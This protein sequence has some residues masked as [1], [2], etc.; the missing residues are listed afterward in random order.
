MG[1]EVFPWLKSL[2]L[3]PEY[4]PTVAEFQDPISYIFKI[5]KE[6]SKYGICKIIPPVS[7]SPKKTIISNLNESLS[8]QNP[9]S[10]PTFTTRRQQIGFCPRKHFR[11]VQK[12]VW[13]S[14]E[15][16]TLAQFEAKAKSFEK[17][18][19]K[20]G[21]NPKRG[22]N[23]L[24]VE[25]LYWKAYMDKPFSIEYAND[26][27]G[28]AFDQ[29]VGGL[30]QRKKEIGDVM[31]VAESQ[32]NMNAASRAKGSLLRFIKE[33]ISG[34]NSPMVYMSMLFSWFAW[35]VEDHDLHSLNYMHMG[36]SKTWY[37]VPMDAA[38][39]FEDVVRAHGYGGE[40]NPIETVATLAKKN[41]VMSPEVLLKAGV[42]CCR[43]VQNAGEFVVTFPRAYHSGFSHGFNCAEATNIATPGWLMVARDAAI[44]RVI[45]NFAPLVSHTQLHYD[46]AL[47]LSANGRK[48]IR[49]EPRSSRLKDKLKGEGEAMVKRLFL[50]DMMKN[51]KLLDLLGQ[52]SPI[53]VLSEEALDSWIP[54]NS[55]TDMSL[56]LCI[57]NDESLSSSRR[58]SSFDS[59]DSPRKKKMVIVK[60]GIHKPDPASVF[61]CVTCGILC[62]SCVAIVQPSKEAAGYLMSTRG[63]NGLVAANATSYTNVVDLGSSSEREVLK[64]DCDRLVD[65]PNK[66]EDDG[67][68]TTSVSKPQE[69]DSALK[70]VAIAYGDCSDFEERDDSD[71]SKSSKY[72]T[73]SDGSM[74]RSEYIEEPHI[75]T[76]PEDCSRTHIFCLDHALEVEKSL[77]SVG[78]VH[79][80][81]LCHP[82]YPTIDEEARS[83]AKELGT[84][85]NWTDLGYRDINEYDNAKIRLALDNDETEHG[86]QDWVVRLG[87]D[88]FYSARLSQSPNYAKQMPYNSVIHNAIGR[89][90]PPSTE[91]TISKLSGKQKKLVVAGKW[92]GK[93]WMWNQ[94][95]PLLVVRDLEQHDETSR[96]V[97]SMVEGKPEIE[98]S[99]KRKMKAVIVESSP[100]PPPASPSPPLLI[101]GVRRPRRRSLRKGTIPNL[102]KKPRE[103]DS[104]SDSDSDLD[105][106]S[107]DDYRPTR[108]GRRRRRMTKSQ[109]QKKAKKG[110]VSEDEDEDEDEEEKEGE[111]GCDVV[112]CKM[113]FGSKEEAMAHKRNVCLVEGCGK[114]FFSHK[115]LLQHRRVHL[116]DRPI[117]CPWPGCGKTFKWK[118]AKTEHIRIHTNARP[119]LCKE[120]GC[121]K[122]FRF[123]SD[124][125]RHK[126]DTGH[127][128]VKKKK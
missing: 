105:S 53:A 42:P 1:E 63:V 101:G 37:G 110:G 23:A 35:H 51:N 52:G 55:S 98:N 104:D 70:L 22:L 91:S 120:E 7:T 2:P 6:A 18:Y 8:S 83:M 119:Y 33:E 49:P 31:T 60:N 20:K 44:R 71:R 99:R 15:H 56:G 75:N 122:R 16:Y 45:I 97:L 9:D 46:L 117:Q 109:Q 30:K 5:E 38:V 89:I 126:R 4:H 34:V 79:M 50:Q 86:N 87:L 65:V 82:D 121:G 81:L 27:P 29:T 17:I 32:W 64:G 88:I 111:F 61:S 25:T 67:S 118:W 36:A 127:S 115:Y 3:A 84:Y 78:G 80:L 40:I 124:F 116:A 58:R 106:D 59:F 12:S 108:T 112:G 41:T 14:R 47:S 95:H 103:S 62:Y 123:V 24:E 13:E 43:L 10:S 128:V 66:S 48:S 19:L 107:D 85:Q 26:M 93:V 39:A 54:L 76:N 77:Q 21:S 113:R 74:S 68:G 100:S 69:I 73:E 28:S 96:S 94:V 102:N 114:I 125:S 92:C 57:Q 90:P 72:F 11:P